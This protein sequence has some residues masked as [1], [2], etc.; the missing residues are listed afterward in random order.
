MMDGAVSNL[1][2]EV[3]PL[4]SVAPTHSISM[5]PIFSRR[6][7]SL[8][9]DP[10]SKRSGSTV[11]HPTSGNSTFVHVGPDQ[12]DGIPMACVDA[13][14]EYVVLPPV[15]GCP[16]SVHGHLIPIGAECGGFRKDIITRWM[17]CRPEVAIYL[18]M[19]WIIIPTKCRVGSA[20]DCFR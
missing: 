1:Y 15:W 4:G 6:R 5:T 12:C 14:S 19:H 13:E 11:T 18:E 16:H 3:H 10:T 17:I 9:V 2:S 20:D 8:C 7:W